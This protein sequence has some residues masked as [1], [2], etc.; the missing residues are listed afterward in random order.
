MTLRPALSP[1]APFWL[2]CLLSLLPLSA[3]AWSQAGHRIVGHL[4]AAE[5]TP[6]ARAEVA[7]L[8][9]GEPDPTLAGVSDWADR[10][11]GEDGP[12]GKA[13]APWHYVNYASGTC[14]FDAV[15][16]CPKGDCV[17]GAINRNFLVLSD[18]QRP[19]AERRDALK[20]LV[21]FVGDV[22]Q[23]LHSNPRRDRGGND[24]QVNL[25]GRGTNLHAIWD[26]TLLES[27]GLAPRAYAEALRREPLLP[28]DPTRGSQTPAL[29][30]ALQ[31]C[32]LVRQPGVYPDGHVIGDDYI[33][34]HRPIAERR[35]REAGSR[36]AALLN[37]ALK[38]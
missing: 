33:Q 7:R 13:T 16:D 18:R 28:H 20:F 31:S 1:L 36:L 34:A 35:L 26:H 30:W 38:D 14:D 2:A 17:V 21:H 27:R 4:A 12:R 29:D 37:H 9:A 3:H 11:R 24:Y 32:R 6:S 10:L 5:L 23:P 15:L 8:L 22:H 25:H 19:L